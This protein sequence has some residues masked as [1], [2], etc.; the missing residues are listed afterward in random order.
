MRMSCATTQYVAIFLH[1]LLFTWVGEA[2]LPW[3]NKYEPLSFAIYHKP[4]LDPLFGV[5]QPKAVV[6]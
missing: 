2:I 3:V 1:K 5:S 4:S 6:I